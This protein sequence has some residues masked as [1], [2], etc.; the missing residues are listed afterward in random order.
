MIK[1]TTLSA[2]AAAIVLI[3]SA[4]TLNQDTQTKKVLE[5]GTVVVNTTTL[6]KKIFGFRDTTPLE[7]SL[8]DGKIVK[9]EALPNYETPGYFQMLKDAKIF[10]SW[11]GLTPQKAL[12]KEV[13]AVSGATYS[14]KAVIDNVRAGMK[15]LLGKTE[16]K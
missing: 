10:D 14:S 9:V 8:K 16:E 12:D 5:D 6:G 1:R 15:F 4:S 13:D 3:L 7:I 2:A 11:N